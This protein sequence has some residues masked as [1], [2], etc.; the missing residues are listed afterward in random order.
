MGKRV[1]ESFTTYEKDGLDQSLL[2]DGFYVIKVPPGVTHCALTHQFAGGN[3]VVRS[4][5]GIYRASGG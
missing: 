4:V 5:T 3:T 2:S 1:D